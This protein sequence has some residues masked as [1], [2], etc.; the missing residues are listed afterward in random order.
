MRAKVGR[1]LDGLIF[2]RDKQAISLFPCVHQL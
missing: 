1:Q 2:L